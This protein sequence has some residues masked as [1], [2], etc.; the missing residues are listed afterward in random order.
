MYVK[1]IYLRSGFF[2]RSEDGLYHLARFRTFSNASPPTRINLTRQRAPVPTVLHAGPRDVQHPSWPTTAPPTSSRHPSP[3]TWIIP[4]CR[5]RGGLGGG[6]VSWAPYAEKLREMGVDIGGDRYLR[7]TKTQLAKAS[8]VG[9]DDDDQPQSIK[10]TPANARTPTHHRRRR[11][12]GTRS[13][14]PAATI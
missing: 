9:R 8:R 4:S 11:T 6:E 12:S 3:T 5:A 2:D 10:V 13:Q 14:C 7:I 1:P